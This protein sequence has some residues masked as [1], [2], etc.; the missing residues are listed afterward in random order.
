ERAKAIADVEGLHYAYIGNVPGHPAE[1]TYCPQ[2]G[3]AVIDRTGYI[4]KDIRVTNGK[5]NSCGRVIAGVW[6]G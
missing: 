3:Q 4:V 6:G 2:C 5:C 1:K